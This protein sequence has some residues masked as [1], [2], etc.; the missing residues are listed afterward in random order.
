MKNPNNHETRKKYEQTDT[1]LIK[2]SYEALE[3]ELIDL[4]PKV[5]TLTLQLEKLKLSMSKLYEGVIKKGDRDYEAALVAFNEN[6]KLTNLTQLSIVSLE[7]A[8]AAAALHHDSEVEN[9]LVVAI[10]NAKVANEYA[11]RYEENSGIR[12][13]KS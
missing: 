3:D 9:L 13:A 5:D 1:L 12:L 10:R 2:P 7:A 4:Y 6:V 8:I 11:Q